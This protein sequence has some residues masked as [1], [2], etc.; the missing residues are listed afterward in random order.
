MKKFGTTNSTIIHFNG[1]DIECIFNPKLKHSYIQI[2]NQKVIVKTSFN[3]NIFIQ[4]LLT[5]KSPWIMSKLQNSCKSIK[6]DY[7]NEVHYLGKICQIGQESDFIELKQAI[8][9]LKKDENITLLHD[10]F[11]KNRATVFLRDRLEYYANV[12]GLRFKEMKVRK[13]KRRW[14]SCDSKR[15]I[16]FNFYLMKQNLELID[17]VVVHELAHLKEMNHSKK[18]YAI[19]EKYI[20]NYKEIEK[21]MKEISLSY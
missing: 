8:E 12:M 7:F 18:F 15:V 11:Y 3:S 6:Y 16:T 10:R 5:K 20:P 9:R 1:L 13:M 19:V 14:G 21:S 4:E 17:Y 2:K